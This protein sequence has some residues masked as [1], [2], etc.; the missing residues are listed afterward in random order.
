MVASGRRKVA[1]LSDEDLERML[2]L[3]A[4]ADSVEL[5]LTLPELEHRAATSALEIDPLDAQI[6]QV[7]FFD[8]PDLVLNQHG[9]V[10]RARR[11]QGRVTTR[12]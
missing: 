12:S 2:H 8:T 3:T 7:F 10:A 5:K 1:E 11:V 6:R 4:G 9:I